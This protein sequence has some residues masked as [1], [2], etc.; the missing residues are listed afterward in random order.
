MVLPGGFAYGD[1]L[2][3]GVI[4]RFSPVMRAVAAFAADGGLVL[5]IC[6]GFQVLAEAGLVPGAL[7]RNRS[8][9]FAGRE[10]AHRRGA[11]RHAVHARARRSAGRCACRSPTA[12]AATSPTTPTLDALE[13]DG[14][15]LFRYV[16]ADGAV[17][18]TGRA[19]ANPNGSLRAIAGVINA[20]GNVAGLMPHPERAAEAVLGSD[21]GAGIIR[22][23]VESAGRAAATA[24]RWSPVRRPRDDRHGARAPWSRCTAASASPT[25]SST[26]SATGWAGATPTTSS[27]RCSA[28]CGASTARTRARKPLLRTLPTAGEGVVAGPGENAG[29]ISIGDGLAVAFKIESHNHPSAVEPYQGAATGVGGI[30][31]DIFTMG[32]RP[33][34][35]LDA[36]RFGDPADARTRHLVDGVV[37]GRRRLRQL[38]RRADGR[39]RARL[40]P[41]LR[42]ATRS[43]TSWPSGCWRSGC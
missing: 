39:R 22:S 23:L 29:V 3:A 31:R 14:Q 28:S 34:A 21:D 16:D 11:P 38:R 26:R 37:R 13:R 1:Y 7:L 12:R 24:G 6:N 5:G 18:R 8:L 33:I 35:V 30:L 41:D 42:R 2:R 25:R 32:A 36:L 27:S 15:V 9:R 4:A 17:G 10:V 19:P 20:A 43:S 40:R